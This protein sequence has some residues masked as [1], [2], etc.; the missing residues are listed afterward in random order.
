MNKFRLLSFNLLF[1]ACLLFLN[2][3][4]IHA[5]F[6]CQ[7]HDLYYSMREGEIGLL[8][9]YDFVK[10][11]YAKIGKFP[12]VADIDIR[13]NDNRWPVIFNYNLKI[14]SNISNR[15]IWLEISISWMY[16]LLIINVSIYIVNLLRNRFQSNKITL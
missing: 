12:S 11:N 14:N 7:A 9:Q 16:M 2:K 15:M 10:S 5:Q 3:S 4:D 1:I 6:S 13:Y 8:Y